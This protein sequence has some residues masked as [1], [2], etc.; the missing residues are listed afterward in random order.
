VNRLR[1]LTIGGALLAALILGVFAY[2]IAD[3][4]SDDKA[5][6]EQRFQDVASVSA[7]VTNGIFDASFQGTQTQAS[8]DFAGPISQQALGEYQAQS[9]AIYLAVYDEGGDRL[10]ATQGAPQPGPA[11]D[12]A[13]ETGQPRLSDVMGSGEEAV[14]EFAIPYE[15]PTGRRIFVSGT[16]IKPFADF[17]AASLSDLPTEFEDAETAMV[18]SN[19][20]V[21]GG[22]NL[23]V[24]PG[25]ELDDPDLTEALQT[26]AYGEYGDD[27]YFASS[28]ITSSPFKIVLN[29]SNDELYA[30]VSGTTLQ[31]S[32]FAAF[33][34]A[35]FGGLFLLRRA[36]L[37]SAELQRKELNE[38][39]AVEINDNIIQGLALAKYKLQAGEGQASADQVSET[40]RE[41]QRLVS[42]LLGD[43]EVKAGQ[44]RREIA[45]ETERPDDPPPE[46]KQ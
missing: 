12:T 24:Q 16:P 38:H 36:L 35:L 1:A 31:W 11:V 28:P 13:R 17:L 7:A 4:Q 41:A 10:G 3:E 25:E 37:A 6:V 9:Q 23:S 40:L 2:L 32:I 39:H 22:D 30:S 20:V 26:E 18:D 19:G 29:E 21:L 46:A 14:I 33:T 42:N 15:T 5:D 43:A 27:R 34:L 8:E 45:A 44:L